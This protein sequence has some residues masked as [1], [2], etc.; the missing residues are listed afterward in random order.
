MSSGFSPFEI[1]TSLSEIETIAVGR[2]IRERRRLVKAYGSGRWRKRKGIA[3]V[4]LPDGMTRRAE[5]HWYEAASI[6]RREF[7]LKRF[8][9]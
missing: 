1:L 7:K 3:W 8:L 9:D 2:A 6:G 4:R 5:I